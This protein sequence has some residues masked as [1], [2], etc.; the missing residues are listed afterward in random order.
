MIPTRPPKCPRSSDGGFTLLE[1]SIALAILGMGVF[2]LLQSQYMS[3]DL[4]S[5]VNDQ[6]NTEFV[7]DQALA[8]AEVD[9]LA[10]NDKGEGDLGELYPDYAYAYETEFIDETALPGLMEV[11]LNVTGPGVDEEMAFRVYDGVQIAQP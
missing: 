5:I 9:I 1:I 3:L 6:V 2:V 4:F 11:T 8:L 10:G 7:V